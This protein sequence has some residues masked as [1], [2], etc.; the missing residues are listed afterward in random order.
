[1]SHKT[2]LDVDVIINGLKALQEADDKAENFLDI[3]QKINSMKLKPGM[4]L[5]AFDKQFQKIKSTIDS[6]VVDGVKKFSQFNNLS[7]SELYNNDELSESIKL[8]KELQTSSLKLRDLG[9]I[10]NDTFK[11]YRK[12]FNSVFKNYDPDTIYDTL[13]SNI[14][15]N[16]KSINSY[17]ENIFD[18]INSKYNTYNPSFLEESLNEI[19]KTVSKIR[20]L[21]PDFEI[22]SESE[23]QPL[24]DYKETIASI[25][26]MMDNVE[27]DDS[28]F[29]S[30]IPSIERLGI[31]V[32]SLREK[33]QSIPKLK[34]DSYSDLLN[35][36]KSTYSTDLKDAN[37]VEY[38]YERLIELAK[39]Y[40]NISSKVGFKNTDFELGIEET[41][42]ELSFMYKNLSGQEAPW[43]KLEDSGSIFGKGIGIASAEIQELIESIQ[44]LISSLSKISDSTDFAKLAED[45]SKITD[46]IQEMSLEF[47]N[48]FSV[49]NN[50]I[51][52]SFDGVFEKTRQSLENVSN[53]KNI[54]D[55]KNLNTNLDFS[56]ITEQITS[57]I[58]SLNELVIAYKKVNEEK[59]NPELFGTDTSEAIN[60]EVNAAKS[61]PSEFDKATQSKA[62]FANAN[63]NVKESAKTSAPEIKNE[64]DSAEDAED[65]IK[66]LSDAAKE[67]SAKPFKD[68]TIKEGSEEWK[69]IVDK[70]NEANDGMDQINKIT[71]SS[72]EDKDGNPITKYQISRSNKDKTASV[73]GLY[74]LNNKTGD[75]ELDNQSVSS[76]LAKQRSLDSK[77]AK[78][79]QKDLNENYKKG[80]NEIIDLEKEKA[81]IIKS[82]DLTDSA[83]TTRLSEINEEISNREKNLKSIQ[84]ENSV[85]EEQNEI[86][87]KSKTNTNESINK[88]INNTFS[89]IEK[90][91]SEIVKLTDK[92]NSAS[93]PEQKSSLLKQ[94]KEAN[95]EF[96]SLIDKAEFYSD[97]ITDGTI[98]DKLTSSI[99]KA[100]SEYEKN[101]E[102][103][104]SLKKE[105]EYNKNW[106]KANKENEKRE[107]E[108]QKKQEQLNK[109]WYKM[110]EDRA[111]QQYDARI[112]AQEAA[113]KQEEKAQESAKK[114]EEK[115]Q[116]KLDKQWYKM[117][118][119]KEK[120]DYYAKKK[121]EQ[122]AQEAV[123]K[124]E[125]KNQK[126]LIEAKEKLQNQYDSIEKTANKRISSNI[127]SARQ[128][129][130]ID[131]SKFEE[132]VKKYEETAERYVEAQKKLAEMRS[133]GLAEG[134]DD[135]KEQVNN[136]SELDNSLKEIEKTLSSGIYNKVNSK[137]EFLEGINV[138]NAATMY[139]KIQ[140]YAAQLSQKYDGKTVDITDLTSNKLKFTV[141]YDDSIVKYTANIDELNNQLRIVDFSNLKK[142]AKDSGEA[143]VSAASDME[144]LKAGFNAVRQEIG[145]SIVNYVS[146]SDA[147]RFFRDGLDTV[148]QFNDSM[149][150]ISM[151]MDMSK[152]KINELGK[153]IIQVARDTSST[154]S[155]ANQVSEI[156]ANMNETAENITRSAQSTIMLS[157]HSGLE[158]S[159]ASDVVQ[160]VVNQYKEL[161]GQENYVVDSL[162]AVS[163]QMKMNF[164]TG[165]EYMSQGLQKSGSIAK[166][167]GMSYENLIATIG[168]LSEVTRQSGDVTGNQIKTITA[169]LGRVTDPEG[170]AL[171]E[172][173]V[174][175]I[176]KAYKSVG[177]ELY[178]AQGEFMGMEK[179]LALL[180]EQWGTLSQA[181]KNYIAEKSAGTR[182]INAFK[183]WMDNYDRIQKLTQAATT[184]SGTAIKNQAIFDETYTAKINQF[185]A[186]VDSL[187]MTMVDSDFTKS[188]IS[189]LTNVLDLVTQIIDKF[190]ALGTTLVGFVGIKGLDLVGSAL[191]GKENNRLGAAWEVL[192]GI[193]PLKYDKESK[194]IGLNGIW[195]TLANKES[196]NKL[197]YG[198]NTSTIKTLIN[199]D[200]VSDI[201]NQFSLLRDNLYRCIDTYDEFG[202]VISGEDIEDVASS[203]KITN[204]ELINFVKNGGDISQVKD[205]FGKFNESVQKSEGI[206]SKLGSGLKSIGTGLLNLGID[207]AISFAVSS[208]IKLISDLIHRSEI[209]IEKGKEAQNTI[210]NIQSEFDSKK[211]IVNDSGKRYAELVQKAEK[212]SQGNYTQ[213]DLSNDEWAEFLSI[214]NQLAEIMPQNVAHLD[215]EGNSMLNLGDSTDAVNS[216]LSEYIKLQEQI[217]NFNIGNNLQDV[218]T[219]IFEE[220]KALEKRNEEL[221]KSIEDYNKL[222]DI[223]SI[224]KSTTNSMKLLSDWYAESP[225]LKTVYSTISGDS[226]T[227]SKLLNVLEQAKWKMNLSDEQFSIDYDDTG[228]DLETGENYTKFVARITALT[229]D[230]QEKLNDYLSQIANEVVESMGSENAQNLA[231]LRQNEAFIKANLQSILPYLQSYA[232]TIGQFLGL[233]LGDEIQT[234]LLSNVNSVIGQLDINGLEPDQLKAFASDTKSWIYDNYLQP[235][236]NLKDYDKDTQKSVANYINDL[237]NTDYSD[238]SVEE[239]KQQMYGANIRKDLNKF[240]TDKD[241]AAL[242]NSLNLR[243]FYRDFTEKSKII[244]EAYPE[245][246][247]NS[248]ETMREFDIVV[249][250]VTEGF[251]GS[252]S[253]LLDETKRKLQ[254]EIDSLPKTKFSDLLGD[255]SDA[256]TISGGAKQLQTAFSDLDGALQTLKSNE[257][258]E[259]T[260]LLELKNKYPELNELIS[261]TGNLEQALSKIQTTK[262]ADY[263]GKFINETRKLDPEDKQIASDYLKNLMESMDLSNVDFNELSSQVYSYLFDALQSEYVNVPEFPQIIQSLME[264][265]LS[266]LDFGQIPDTI[267]GL[268]KKYSFDVEKYTSSMEALK[269][270]QDEWN[271]SGELSSK[272]IQDLSNVGFTAQQITSGMADGFQNLGVQATESFRQL[273]ISIGESLPTELQSIW[274][275]FW[276]QVIEEQVPTDLSGMFT[277]KSSDVDRYTASMNALKSA[278]DDYTKSGKLSAETIKALSDAGYDAQQITEGMKDGFHD[279]T[280]Q[281][282]AEF[283]TWAMKIA[284][285][286]RNVGKEADATAFLDYCSQIKQGLLDLQGY[287]LDLGNIV[288]FDTTLYGDWKNA[289]GTEDAYARY[290]EIT[291]YK[292][293]AD[294]L[295]KNGWYGVDDL[296]TYAKLLGKNEDTLK[297]A[298]QNYQARSDW[299]SKYL[300]EDSSGT[301]AFFNMAIEKTK[302]LD[303]N[304][305]RLNSN[306]TFDVQIDSIKEFADNIGI[307]TEM[308]LYELQSLQSM[309]Y[310]IDFDFLSEN[311]KNSF[312]QID[313][314]AANAGQ[315]IQNVISSMIQLG[316]SGQDVSGAVQTALDSI[317]EYLANGGNQEVAQSM[318]DSLN[319]F[320]K[321]N[322]FEIKG[323]KLEWANGFSP[324]E[325]LAQAKAE[326]EAKTITVN[327]ETKTVSQNG[328]VIKTFEDDEYGTAEQNA[329]NYSNALEKVNEARENN[330]SILENAQESLSGYTEEQLRSLDMVNGAYDNTFEG[331]QQAEQA[332]DNIA[333]K[334]GLGSTNA[335]EYK[336]NI[337]GLIEVLKDYG[338]IESP[339]QPDINKPTTEKTQADILREEARAER[340]YT[341]TPPELT[342]EEKLSESVSNV[343]MEVG[344][345][346]TSLSD[347][348]T[349]FQQAAT[350]FTDVSKFIEA[351]YNHENSPKDVSNTSAISQSSSKPV[352]PLLS[353]TLEANVSQLLP[354]LENQTVEIE[355][356]LNVD[357]SELKS[358]E[359]TPIEVPTSLT[360]QNTTEITPSTTE[361]VTNTTQSVDLEYEGQ[362][363]D[364]E[365]G[366]Q[367]VHIEYEGH[368]D[369]FDDGKQN[370]NIDYQGYRPQ[371]DPGS[372]IVNVTYNGLKD[373]LDPLNQTVFV[374][375]VKLKASGTLMQ[376]RANGT[377]RISSSNF[378]DGYV[379]TIGKARANGQ[380]GEKEDTKALTGELG[381]ELVVRDNKFF[382]VGDNGPEMV[383]LKKGDI[384][385]N[386]RQ[387]EDILSK[388]YTTGRGN[389]L[390]GA[391]ANGTIGEAR[392]LGDGGAHVT[393]VIIPTNSQSDNSAI[394]SGVQQVVQ[395]VQ[396]ATTHTK[397]SNEKKEKIVN[398]LSD[399][400]IENIENIGKYI[401]QQFDWIQV[402]LE[403]LQR[404]A[405]NFYSKY[406]L[407]SKRGLIYGSN[408]KKA[409]NN[410]SQS[411]S[412][413]NKSIDAN[414]KGAVR[415]DKQAETINKKQ[416][417]A[418]QKKAGNK[419]K[420]KAYDDLVA[421][422]DAIKTLNAGGI[423]DL[424]Q[425]S[426]S[427]KTAIEN[428]K[429][430]KDSANSC[431]DSVLSLT[432]SLLD[433]YEALYNLP[434]EY[435]SEKLERINYQ[436]DV[437]NANTA[438][439][440]AGAK[441]M[442]AAEKNALLDQQH[443]YTIQKTKANKKAYDETLKNLEKFG[444]SSIEE[445]QLALDNAK[446]NKTKQESLYESKSKE[447]SDK[448]KDIKKNKE[449]WNS[450]TKNQRQRIKNGKTIKLNADQTKNL[451]KEQKKEIETYNTLAKCALVL[452]KALNGEITT[453]EE[454]S[455]AINAAMG[456]GSEYAKS[457][458]EEIQEAIDNEKQYFENV[459]QQY[460][461]EIEL[462]Q[463]IQDMIQ[464][465]GEYISSKEYDPL[466]NKRT[467]ELNAL[468]NQLQSSLDTIEKGKK[469]V[470]NNL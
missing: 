356:Q 135:I 257:K 438:A 33:L 105:K 117:E 375:E 325:K 4:D 70:I 358:V 433:Q 151:T 320:G 165:I 222:S 364:F 403:Y 116:E 347:L 48:A 1:M 436:L 156:Y 110:E 288:K 242:M 399:K 31:D 66:E 193:N 194:Q 372:Q 18:G 426:E 270:A 6:F 395:N 230:Q 276:N 56:S 167:A 260:D 84:A 96:T 324:E 263:I 249:N 413:T 5:S 311:I 333:A 303:S 353:P 341:Y 30:M 186:A 315:Q 2:R 206:L 154:I 152:Q 69:K 112:K 74:V 122:K 424:T 312:D 115:A 93:S 182:N 82:N 397:K 157:N 342:A 3:I 134:S 211:E 197:L 43:K 412:Y 314:S 294:E 450:L 470:K 374:R 241:A 462:R 327:L 404:K 207:M 47:K 349:A 287:S 378:N 393:D 269:T 42:K 160:G 272:T 131:N 158:A 164:G 234:T 170:E 100:K 334:L 94:L 264:G 392:G 214:S 23:I 219:G 7:L 367:T 16:K 410:L 103:E 8:L 432:S 199:E 119:N 232:G 463:K 55:G 384:V 137:G 329:T 398:L 238:L 51:E 140:D 53:V 169:R 146:L 14:S 88:T 280:A 209:L 298:T 409:K 227:D 283:D 439:A 95:D 216:S 123:R 337:E 305:V 313:M 183:V 296:Q 376:S 434:L 189:G 293:T 25:V 240:I 431:R 29:T 147:I 299:W 429:N 124:Q 50:D 297:S 17:I 319:E 34:I 58:A 177:I 379:G 136:V 90:A 262:A 217:S 282:A 83:S 354:E 175:D 246:D 77:K 449:L 26:N 184:S 180:N 192:S 321:L 75:L 236:A 113:R 407:F 64:G 365:D 335:E 417:K 452:Q 387:T 460:E 128:G 468:K 198:E 307:T 427:V 455:A 195:K 87:K 191:F 389:V 40:S 286:L 36:R 361:V 363:S 292:K 190:G 350:D 445:G 466:I 441:N 351:T 357:D 360:V 390:G 285:D 401:Q 10:D 318:I 224:T 215:S 289:Q 425:Y 179:A 91:Y 259:P 309:G 437:F 411:I 247:I 9:I 114:Q 281:T 391:R 78:Q 62:D 59:L 331:S 130:K 442:T 204:T 79:D 444:V 418:F 465:R 300:T 106:D 252:L 291:S 344:N 405:D 368:K 348:S 306:G 173:E 159:T 201:T 98:E 65:K 371:F 111:K 102:K 284:N 266:G 332:L 435:A 237:F 63:K 254:E 229:E 12:Y 89:D 458:E 457:R 49:E 166:E 81:N 256:S 57:L 406:E 273:A 415:Y 451:R 235:I 168:V 362:Q 121:S 76:D 80:I 32:D 178:N 171:T 24:V 68:Q 148:N 99:T 408:Y 467:E 456:A 239:Y 208:A 295:F 369:E 133:N 15:R 447:A 385:F 104:D 381:R 187:Q 85:I 258:I 52:G 127:T 250:L 174:S 279:M 394:N 118:E 339:Q 21:D 355:G 61:L 416:L 346:E 310:S 302:E 185:E 388:G 396:S 336:N 274:T 352:A 430:Y 345:V 72:T 132:Y 67:A 245:L 162:E 326:L 340:E 213:G 196:R 27:F 11:N 261:Q 28:V 454:L 308:A 359:E 422:E 244:Q 248:L 141:D 38:E 366:T 301:K 223:K 338:L 255:E 60:E 226:R 101:K 155:S 446:K 268:F 253:Q 383:N 142:G 265:I 373:H 275:D 181:S 86:R 330:N 421:Y 108:A 143:I 172:S 41:I 290:N 453:M 420:G 149:S 22:F 414:E 267:S 138:S 386:H 419:K 317:K 163:A 233:D 377:P 97:I 205:H 120:S 218:V 464:A 129:E 220:N 328:E 382:T 35:A 150:T 343:S 73:T 443:N 19:Y 225:D 448:G 188:L 380:W 107:Q 221:E 144:K 251:D 46:N 459:K 461:N 231:E 278:Q 161:A 202:N 228:Y 400:V 54:I 176:A 44:L 402:R 322:G 277:L 20:S 212:D 145:Q 440:T 125:L 37:S 316:Q 323:L 13:S 92:L 200:E 109:N 370:V 243:S 139:A 71:R 304:F 39:D 45:I 153:S 428:Y 271:L 210:K 423:I 203:L 126:E 469:T